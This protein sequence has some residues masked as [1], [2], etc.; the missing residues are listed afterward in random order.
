MQPWSPNIG[1]LRDIPDGVTIDGSI[2]LLVKTGV[3]SESERPFFGEK[4]YRGYPYRGIWN[5]W[6]LIGRRE[7]MAKPA[8]INDDHNG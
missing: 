1:G 4:P 3:L 8:T 6:G 7:P 5:L 2:D